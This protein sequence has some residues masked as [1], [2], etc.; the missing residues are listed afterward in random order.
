[1]EDFACEASKRDFEFADQ[2]QMPANNLMLLFRRL[3]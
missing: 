3:A 2:R 1:V